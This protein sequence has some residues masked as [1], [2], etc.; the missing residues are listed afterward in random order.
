MYSYFGY[1]CTKAIHICSEDKHVCLN[2][3]EYKEVNIGR[4]KLLLVD[5][6][7]NVYP[8]I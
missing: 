8:Y 2:P 3:C 7:E 5:T 4:K 6:E 1:Y